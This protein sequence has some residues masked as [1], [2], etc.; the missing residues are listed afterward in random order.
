[1]PRWTLENRERHALA[2]R[3]WKPWTRSTGPKTPEGKARS[4]RNAWK[5]GVRTEIAHWSSFLRELSQIGKATKQW[6]SKQARP[7]PRK[8]APS[9]PQSPEEQWISAMENMTDN[10]IASLGLDPGGG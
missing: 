7:K 5:G 10:L 6:I 2:M 4:S 9:V 1:M 3:A 8:T